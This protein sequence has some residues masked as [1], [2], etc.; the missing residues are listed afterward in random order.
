[1]LFPDQIYQK[2]GFNEVK[3]EI[4]KECIEYLSIPTGLKKSEED[5]KRW[6]RDGFLFEAIQKN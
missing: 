4:K 2:L 1:M 6:H 5:A 3:E